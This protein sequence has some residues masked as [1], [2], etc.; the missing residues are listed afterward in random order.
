MNLRVQSSPQHV[1]APS[2]E[3]ALA[4]FAG[5]WVTCGPVCA[6]EANRMRR[7]ALHPTAWDPHRESE[8]GSRQSGFCKVHSTKW[9]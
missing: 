3:P 2:T 7:E 8:S 1:E 6:R 5:L 4:S 9:G